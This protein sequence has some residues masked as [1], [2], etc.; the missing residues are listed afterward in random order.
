MGIVECQVFELAGMYPIP[1]EG[2]E[3]YNGT[4]LLATSNETGHFTFEIEAGTY[5]LTCV[6]VGYVGLTEEVVVIAGEITSHAF[7]MVPL[8]G[9]GDNVIPSGTVLNANFPNPFNPETSIKFA[10]AS[11]SQVQ[12]EIYNL[13]GQKV[14]TLINER[15]NPGIYCYVW[16][17]KDDSDK[18]VTSGV[19]FYKMKAGNYTSTKKMILLK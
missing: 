5:M 6:A 9:V 15:M 13:A 11:E 1:I 10:I 19:Y 8:T 18:S 14:K 2:A 16:N 17:G 7:I 12:V 3:I 4:E